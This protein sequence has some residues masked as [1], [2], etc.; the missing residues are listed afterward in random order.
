MF[1]DERNKTKLIVTKPWRYKNIP[2]Y[3]EGNMNIHLHDWSV[4]VKRRS[5]RHP[6]PRNNYQYNLQP[7]KFSVS[8]SVCV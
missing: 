6:S 1:R 3:L 4:V 7:R 5:G 8:S 2:I